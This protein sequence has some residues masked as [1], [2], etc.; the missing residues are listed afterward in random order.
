MRRRPHWVDRD[1]KNRNRLAP[2]S[3]SQLFK[4]EQAREQIYA[5][6]QD[7]KSDVFDY[8]EKVYNATRRQSSANGLSPAEFEQ[9]HLHRLAGV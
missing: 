4:R 9:R 5:S 8:I 6:R 3:F 7:A 2:E 1:S